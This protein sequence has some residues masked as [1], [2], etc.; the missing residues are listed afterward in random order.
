MRK[1]QNQ[2]IFRLPLGQQVWD[3]LAPQGDLR[4]KN[5]MKQ[6]VLRISFQEAPILCKNTKSTNLYFDSLQ[7]S[8]FG[9]PWHLRETSDQKID[10]NKK[11]LE[12]NFREGVF[13]VQMPNSKFFI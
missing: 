6:I 10:R 5:S 2:N 8:P 9:G 1:C 11:F 13:N 7:T 12:F 4:S 3:V